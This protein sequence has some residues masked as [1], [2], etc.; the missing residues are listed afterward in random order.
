MYV[1]NLE[2]SVTEKDLE[3]LFA[4]VGAVVY[5]KVIL[6]PEGRSKGFGFVE[7]ETED[8]AKVAT[9][10]FNQSNYKERTIVVNEARPQAERSFNG[11]ERQDGGSYDSRN[12]V[13]GDLN[14]K[15]R[16]LR[17]SLE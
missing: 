8:L 4:E 3:E 14:Y 17:R 10:K 6:S 16:K 2:Y 12:K 15:L 11:G 13:S 9:E 5:S 7:M 1:G